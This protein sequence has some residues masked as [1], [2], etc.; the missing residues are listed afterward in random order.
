MVDSGQ[1]TWSEISILKLIRN[2]HFIFL[3]GAMGLV[4]GILL[5]KNKKMGWILS[6]SSWII[7]CFGTL[8]IFW[9]TGKVDGPIS[10]QNY[11]LIGILILIFIIMAI[12]LTL[13]PFMLKY[14]PDSK[15]W[16]TIA[17]ITLVF[18]IDKLLIK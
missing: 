14:K 1:I 6:F 4:S 8:I 12:V 2:A 9:K 7:Y 16:I 10:T 11:M 17:V 3:S 13:K 18:L 5:L 15:S